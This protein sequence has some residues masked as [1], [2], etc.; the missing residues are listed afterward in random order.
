MGAWEVQRQGESQE[1]DRVVCHSLF[2]QIWL[3]KKKQKSD[4][5]FCR[6]QKTIVDLS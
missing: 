3:Q 5:L 2:F 4:V 1:R 6:P